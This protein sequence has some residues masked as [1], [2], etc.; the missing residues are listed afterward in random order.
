MQVVKNFQTRRFE[1]GV[2]TQ[3]F[4]NFSS[5]HQQQMSMHTASH[6][7][8]TK[9][10]KLMQVQDSDDIELETTM[11]G[12]GTAL[13]LLR[14]GSTVK[15]Q[16]WI[17]SVRDQKHFAFISVN[18]GSC[19]HDLQC[20]AT[21][22]ATATDTDTPHTDIIIHTDTQTN[23]SNSKLPPPLSPIHFQESLKHFTTGCSVEITGELQLSKG[24]GQKYEVAVKSLKLIGICPST[25]ASAS[26]SASVGAGTDA[27]AGGLNTAPNADTGIDTGIEI[28]PY[29]LQ[30]KRHT[31]EYM[32]TIAHL[33]PRANTG[34]AVSRVRST[35]AQATHKYFSE[36]DFI[37]VSF[38]A[39]VGLF[40][41][42]RHLSLSLH[43]PVPDLI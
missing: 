23:H 25:S 22:T 11:S 40:H 31:L 24:S 42:H 21:A 33:R 9:I 32:R 14:V 39:G 43:V 27:A 18:D 37:Y 29:P 6:I 28:K 16:G 35:L 12:S 30:K 13:T 7:K 1:N 41:Y 4:S 20:V 15:V 17:R 2:L 8:R 38:G 19:I 34:A 36:Q 10:K 3:S 26:A 5:T